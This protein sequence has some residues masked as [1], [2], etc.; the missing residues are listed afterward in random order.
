MMQEV[1]SY[2]DN[3]GH[4][5]IHNFIDSMTRKILQ[6]IEMEGGLKQF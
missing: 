6:F 2:W 4:K 5:L 3:M 1:V